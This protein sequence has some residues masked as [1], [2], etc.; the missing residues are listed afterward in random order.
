LQ[1]ATYDLGD[2]A[3]CWIA[4]GSEGR[5][6]PKQVRAALRAADLLSEPSAQEVAVV[7]AF[8]AT[9]SPADQQRL[10]AT[11]RQLQLTPAL[12]EIILRNRERE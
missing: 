7:Q 10:L 12:S 11:W 3:W 4:L 1:R 9:H 8:E 2:I 6:E 5:S